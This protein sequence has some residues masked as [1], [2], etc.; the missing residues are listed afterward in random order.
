MDSREMP[1]ANGIR[2]AIVCASICWLRRLQSVLQYSE[3]RRLSRAPMGNQGPRNKA[4][5]SRLLIDHDRNLEN[6]DGSQQ[7]DDTGQIPGRQCVH[8]R[9][10]S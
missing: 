8:A 6:M 3:D 5:A 10:Q 7:S 9:I 4:Q 1:L 2:L